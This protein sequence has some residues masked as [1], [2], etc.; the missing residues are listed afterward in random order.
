MITKAAACGPPVALG[1]ATIAGCFPMPGPIEI[2]TGLWFIVLIA[3]K[4]W[5]WRIE[6]KQ[7][8]EGVAVREHLHTGFSRM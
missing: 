4:I 3:H 2:L 8:R 6:A 1:A 5:K 7:Y